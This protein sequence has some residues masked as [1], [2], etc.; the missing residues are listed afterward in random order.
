M[1][2]VQPIPKQKIK[3]HKAKNNPVPTENDLC[4]YHKT[5]YA[6]NHEIYYGNRRQLSIKHGMQRRLCFWCHE[7]PEGVHNNPLFNFNLKQEF[8]GIFEVNHSKGEFIKLFGKDYLNMTFEE[9]IKKG[10]A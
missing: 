8:Q 2:Y 9:F 1:E 7:G 5:P 10:A 3:K 4:Y 6:R